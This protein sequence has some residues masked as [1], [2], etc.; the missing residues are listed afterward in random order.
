M[1]PDTGTGAPDDCSH[2]DQI[3]MKN[4]TRGE[5]PLSATA[6]SQFPFDQDGYE[7]LVAA[8]GEQNGGY[9]DFCPPWWDSDRFCWC[10]AARYA[11]CGLR[12]HADGWEWALNGKRHSSAA[13][14]YEHRNDEFLSENAKTLP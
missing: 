8:Y 10:V 7:K 1:S 14:A 3:T 6:C 13:E 4:Q 5:S 2:N 11:D 12:Q 9:E